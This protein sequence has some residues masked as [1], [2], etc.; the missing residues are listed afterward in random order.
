MIFDGALPVTIN[1]AAAA[2]PFVLSERTVFAITVNLYLIKRHD[3]LLNQA[4]YILEGGQRGS[5]FQTF[6]K[7]FVA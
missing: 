7:D 4:I 2:S 3:S 5:S 6:A 1:D